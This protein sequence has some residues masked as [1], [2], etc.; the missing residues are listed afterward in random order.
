MLALFD[1]CAI[2]LTTGKFLD[3]TGFTISTDGTVARPI[4]LED[5]D[6]EYEVVLSLAWT[7]A[8]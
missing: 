5:G 2:H 1:D 8:E 4:P 3:A 6:L 7:A